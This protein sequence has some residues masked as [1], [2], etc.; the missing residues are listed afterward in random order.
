MAAEQIERQKYSQ[1]SDVYAFGVLAGELYERAPPLLGLEA[2]EAAH[3]I[4][5][6]ARL[7][8]EPEPPGSAKQLIDW[9]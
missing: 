6:D 7:P 9:W 5:D 1:A 2:V 8:L 3:A 4:V